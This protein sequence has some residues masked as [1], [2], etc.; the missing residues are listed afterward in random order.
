MKKMSLKG[1]RRVSTT[2]NSTQPAVLEKKTAVK[3][4]CV[5]ALLCV[6]TIFVQS[7]LL[8]SCDLY[9]FILYI[10]S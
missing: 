3:W 9:F 6:L 2:S 7:V 4:G 5:W 1:G 8:N 10:K